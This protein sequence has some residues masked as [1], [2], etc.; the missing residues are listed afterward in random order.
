MHLIDI[1]SDILV[2]VGQN[3]G[4][5]GCTFG[6]HGCGDGEHFISPTL[7]IPFR[8]I[9]RYLLS[10]FVPYYSQIFILDKNK[11]NSIRTRQS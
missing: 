3:E 8:S 5:C 7:S 9:L 1:I 4:I 2:L 6:D 11:Q 10:T